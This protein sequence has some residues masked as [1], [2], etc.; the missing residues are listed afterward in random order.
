MSL[1]EPPA[2]HHGN[3]QI[4]LQHYNITTSEWHS[5]LPG[6]AFVQVA[7]R[8]SFVNAQPRDWDGGILPSVEGTQG[9]EIMSCT[10]YKHRYG[11]F[12]ENNAV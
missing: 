12:D 6:W 4:T 5:I 8:I 1:E 7:E 11:T 3:N 9:L 2:H 10:P